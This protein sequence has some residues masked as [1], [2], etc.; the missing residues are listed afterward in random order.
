VLGL[1]VI[2]DLQSLAANRPRQ[3]THHFPVCI[4]G[5]RKRSLLGIEQAETHDGCNF[6]SRANGAS[7]IAAF[8][9]VQEPTRNAR[10]YRDIGCPHSFLDPGFAEEL[11]EKADCV[12]RVG[13]ER[14]LSLGH[15][16]SHQ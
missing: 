16:L 10:T 4:E 3:K 14:A 9:A 12:R 13:R 2:V 1:E 5:M 15:R 11:A 6:E 7:G 8:N